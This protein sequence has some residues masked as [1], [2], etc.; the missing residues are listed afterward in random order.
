MGMHEQVV[1]IFGGGGGVRGGFWG[2][3]DGAREMER[4][5]RVRGCAEEMEG[6]VKVPSEGC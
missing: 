4:E 6:W 5:G 2:V 3:L 1:G